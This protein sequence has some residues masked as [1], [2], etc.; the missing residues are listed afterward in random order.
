MTFCPTKIFEV[1]VTVTRSKVKFTTDTDIAHHPLIR[2]Q[3][4]KFEPATLNTL[5]DMS[6]TSFSEVKVT[7]SRSKVKSTI[8]P[9]VA[10]LAL[11]GNLHTKFE[12][13]VP[14]TFLDTALTS[15]GL[16]SARSRS[17]SKGQRSNPLM[18]LTLHN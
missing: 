18:N 16:P 8:K 5:R 6:Q 14:H 3:Y 7:A 12:A 2:N 4:T 15:L 11:I 9:D 17:L 10:H 13:A 1:K